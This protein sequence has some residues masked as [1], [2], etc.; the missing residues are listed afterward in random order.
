MEWIVKAV[1]TED[2]AKE[3]VT[4]SNEVYKAILVSANF[5]NYRGYPDVD[6][7]SHAEREL[8]FAPGWNPLAPN[9]DEP[10]YT[11]WRFYYEE[12]ELED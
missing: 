12:T 6:K 7:M 9:L 3:F 2:A 10:D 4:K 5:V 1:K 8:H 11:G